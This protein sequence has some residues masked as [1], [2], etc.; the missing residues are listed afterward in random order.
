MGKTIGTGGGKAFHLEMQVRDHELDQYGVVNNSVYNNYLEHARHEFLIQVG[1]DAAEVAA[2]GRSLALSKL[3]VHYRISLRSR[4][5]FQIVV[6]ISEISG[7]RVMF[8]QTILRDS[9][10][11]LMLEAWAEAVFLDDRG[12]PMRVAQEHREA[13]QPYLEIT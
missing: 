8:H 5:K 1:M 3:T 12:R 9:D 13:F 7:A 2:S 11:A 6:R 10:R 4:D